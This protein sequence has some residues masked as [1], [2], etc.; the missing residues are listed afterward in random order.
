MFV[1]VN[2][3]ETALQMRKDLRHWQHAAE[4]AS[5]CAPQEITSLQQQYAQALEIQG[6]V[7]AAHA[8]FQ[9]WLQLLLLYH[10]GLL[11]QTA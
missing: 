10:S 2:A 5:H 8:I 11:P 4:L 3:E 7:S 6:D 9:V 1:R